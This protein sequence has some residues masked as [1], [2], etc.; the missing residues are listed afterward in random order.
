[1]LSN[2]NIL[3]HKAIGNI[4]IEPFY[5]ELL[6]TNSY[7]VRLG[8][9]YVRQRPGTLVLHYNEAY[10]GKRMWY[11]P[12]LIP[13]EGLMIMPGETVLAHTEEYIGGQNCITSEM[14]AKST[15]AR[16]CVSVCKCAGLGDVGYTSRWTME[17]SNGGN[18]PII[19]QPGDRVAQILFHDVGQV[20]SSYGK[21][22]G[23]Y[24]Q[25]EWTPEDMLPKGQK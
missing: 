17:M 1:M 3:M 7:D 23:R 12:E 10:Y 4:V 21:L 24:G 22:S 16:F 19:F 2:K 11:S 9:W 6:G 13:A 14:R 8:E 20:M 25:G 5:E 15:L 18:R